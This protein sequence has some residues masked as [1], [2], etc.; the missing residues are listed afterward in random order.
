[1]VP[2]EV[3][4]V[5]SKAKMTPIN[6]K[7]F[8]ERAEAKIEELSDSLAQASGEARVQAHLALMELADT[9]N[10]VQSELG[11]QINQLKR[12]TVKARAVID[13]AKVQ[14]N[15]AKAE[16]SDSLIAMQSNLRHIEHKL[17]GLAVQSEAQTRMALERIEKF[18]HDLSQ[19]LR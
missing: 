2:S 1:M 16:A 19:K 18:C 7:D 9:W 3:K 15:L 17:K 13:E 11:K 6:P 10:N 12:G 8:L 14:A 4:S 5:P